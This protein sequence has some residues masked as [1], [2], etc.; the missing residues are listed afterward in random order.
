[1]P[2]PTKPEPQATERRP[3]D[4]AAAAERY[5]RSAAWKRL[6]A[7]M[8]AFT[9]RL[10]AIAREYPRVSA[11][12]VRSI[13]FPRGQSPLV[14][15]ADGKQLRVTDR[16]LTIYREAQ[17]L[18]ATRL[19]PGRTDATLAR[20]IERLGRERA[21]LLAR[22]E[23]AKLGPRH[24]WDALPDEIW[25]EMTPAEMHEAAERDPRYRRYRRAARWGYVGDRAVALADY[26]TA[27]VPGDR[28]GQL[29]RVTRN[30][31]RAYKQRALDLA[32]ELTTLAY[33][34][35]YL[36]DLQVH[37]LTAHA[38]KSRIQKRARPRR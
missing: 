10:D 32:A 16:L 8:D 26:L 29:G 34:F 23:D 19:P 38:V 30:D 9:P 4:V 33:R 12:R 3:V 25:D 13:L 2:R 17:A 27:R 1:V 20:R 24:K 11:T 18:E 35:P 15:L 37:P 28:D 31:A 36:P 6:L 22:L 21:R 7:S 14:V 5:F